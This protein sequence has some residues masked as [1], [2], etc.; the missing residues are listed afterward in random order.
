MRQSPA[1]WPS[2]LAGCSESAGRRGALLI[3]RPAQPWTSTVIPADAISARGRRRVAAKLRDR[4]HGPPGRV[5]SARRAPGR[6]WCGNSSIGLPPPAKRTDGEQSVTTCDQLAALFSAPTPPTG[7]QQLRLQRS[8]ENRSVTL[9]HGSCR[10]A[11]T[12]TAPSVST[13][14]R[15]AWLY[16]PHRI[17]DYAAGRLARPVSAE[18]RRLSCVR[19]TFPPWRNAWHRSPAQPSP[20]PHTPTPSALT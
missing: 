16:A 2:S 12:R 4:E 7:F 8:A 3:L 20:R 13:S 6:K 9:S 14:A 1:G 15:L 10:R 18:A 11:G 19:S 5:P 17:G